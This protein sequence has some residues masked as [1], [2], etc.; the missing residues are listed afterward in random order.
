MSKQKEALTIKTTL[1][2]ILVKV[3]GNQTVASKVLDTERS[4]VRKHYDTN[5][6][7]VLSDG[8]VFRDTGKVMRSEELK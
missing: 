4:T 2:D 6:I 1:R 7:V 5:G 8:R 3:R